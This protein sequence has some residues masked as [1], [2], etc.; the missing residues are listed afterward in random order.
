M[1]S[2]VDTERLMASLLERGATTEMTN[3]GPKGKCA[4]C[5]A[6]PAEGKLNACSAC[7]LTWYCSKDCQLLDWKRGHK[8]ACK[9]LRY[10]IYIY[11]YANTY[12][13][14]VP[15][16]EIRQNELVC[17]HDIWRISG[18]RRIVLLVILTILLCGLGFRV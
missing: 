10:I 17:M 7:K 2:N 13:I 6:K 11:V 3:E 4:M 12:M 16:P 8:Q 14:A 1:G 5:N 18:I 15:P 9:L